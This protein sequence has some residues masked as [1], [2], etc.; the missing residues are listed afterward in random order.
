MSVHSGFASKH[1][2]N[3]Y[4]T[5]VYKLIDVL[6]EKAVDAMNNGKIYYRIFILNNIFITIYSCLWWEKMV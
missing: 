2:E 1:Q 5:L 4:N 6:A 3:V